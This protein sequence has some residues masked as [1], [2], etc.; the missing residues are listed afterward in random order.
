MKHLRVTNKRRQGFTL[1]EL[2]VV[3]VIIG[4]LFGAFTFIWWIVRSAKG[5][6]S[7]SAGAAYEHPATW[8]W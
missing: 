1:I 7:F 3:I 6:K 5:L 4:L 8:L 2:M